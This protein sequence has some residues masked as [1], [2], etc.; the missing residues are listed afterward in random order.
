MTEALHARFD[1][2]I[3]GAG[4]AGCVLAGQLA[5][6]GKARILL[7]EAGGDDRS[8]FIRMPAG[9][10]RVVVGKTWKYA[11][12]PAPEVGG[13]SVDVWQGKV[14]G[15]SSSVNGMVYVRGHLEDYDAWESEY[16][17]TGWNGAEALKYFRK[18]ENN[19]S[20]DDQAHGRF[21]RLPV[22]RPGHCTPVSEY[23]IRAGQEMGLPRLEDL[24]TVQRGVGYYQSTTHGGER[25]STARAY[26]DDPAIR[27]R[28]TIL[29]GALVEK[30]L[31][32]DGRATGVRYRAD[33][34]TVEALAN[35]EVIVSAGG[36]GSAKVL[37]L[38]GI[39]P[40][41]HLA[42][43]GI[44]VK[45]DLPVG[46]NFHDHLHVSLNVSIDAPITL[47]G[48]DK[49]LAAVRN[50]LRW[51]LFRNGPCASNV[52]EAGAALD[53]G[54]EG[55]PDT[56]VF[57]FPVIDSWDNIDG[58]TDPP[59]HGFTVKTCPARPK[60]RGRVTLRSPDPAD[61]PRIDA[62]F[63]S[64]RA[65]VDAHIRAVRWGLD[66]LERPAFRA[67]KGELIAPLP[68]QTVDDAAIEQFVR[69]GTKTTYH[70][71][72]TCRMGNSPT[73]SV[74][75]PTLR[76][77]GIAGLRVIDSSV[78]PAIPSGNTNAPTIM[79]AEKGVDLILQG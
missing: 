10:P 19:D 37:M 25:A 21:G 38:S 74:V 72:G 52:A 20:L 28:V 55:R 13:R 34:K 4:S 70:P 71:V 27:D 48:A 1:Y 47:Y 79:V 51:L 22:S 15:G 36:I 5:R 61:L 49:G 24:S 33:G 56:Q 39:G 44:P 69:Q 68:R 78:F 6:D 43:I 30:V 8:L 9:L 46:H 53:L 14:L 42:Q 11:T 2:I 3:I 59:R 18:A 45:A 7:L 54:G 12:E 31:I 23:F 77:H 40:A 62:N 26:L 29:T 65:D 73:S 32:E 75:D 57:F 58:R 50:G 41:A 76:V 67:L 66:L 16:G 17:C 60:S 63:L 64:V 35:A